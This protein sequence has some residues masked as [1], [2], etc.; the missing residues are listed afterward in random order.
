MKG[1]ILV[2][3][4][5]TTSTAFSQERDTFQPDSVYRTNNVKT[6]IRY[7]EKAQTK[8]KLIYNYDRQGRWIEFIL[9]DNLVED[10]IQMKVEY[11][12]DDTGRLIGETE[13]SYSGDK[14]QTKDSKIEHDEKGKVIKN[15]KTIYGLIYSE[16][17]YT[18]DPLVEHENQYKNG[19][20]YRE[21]TSYFE[22]PNYSNRFT[23]TELADKKAKPRELK[24]PNGKKVKFNPPKEDL[25]WD[26]TFENTL[27]SFGRIIERNRFA[28]G[29]LQD[30]I[31]YKYSD[32]GLLIEKLEKMQTAK[33]ET[34]E[35]F[36][37]KYW[38]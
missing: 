28:N 1:L 25:K 18:Y 17:T 10:K 33:I 26:Y 16:E 38:E 2:F 36:E 8:S 3:G 4:L 31:T 13:T 35:I 37:Y 14:I 9:T 22:Y 20:V 30:K 23:G 12:Y 34:K 11:K 29:E 15:E 19:T 7:S 24:L 6:R 32:K 5:L 27:D 21:Q